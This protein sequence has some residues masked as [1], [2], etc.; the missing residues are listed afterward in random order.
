MRGKTFY[1]MFLLVL[2]IWVA[3]FRTDQPIVAQELSPIL[4]N[5]EVPPF[6]PDDKLDTSD[7]TSLSWME[8]QKAEAQLEKA[9][10]FYT[11]GVP[12]SFSTQGLQAVNADSFGYTWTSESLSWIS[13]EFGTDTNIDDLTDHTGPIDIGFSFNYYENTYTQLYISR[14]GFV[15]FSEEYIY[16]S[17]SEIPSR[18]KPDN[19]IAPHWSPTYNVE[20]YVRYVKGGIYPNRWFAVEWNHVTSSVSTSDTPEN[21]TFEV[22]LYESGDIVFQYDEMSASGSYF[23]QASGIED[24]TGIDGLSLSSY[25]SQI[26]AYSAK[27]IIRPAPAARVRIDSAFQGRFVHPE[28]TE[29]FQFQVRNIGDLGADTFDLL[30]TSS[31]PISLYQAD[32]KTLWS[33]TD[34]D[35]IVDTGALAQGETVTI[36]AKISTPTYVSTGNYNIVTVIARSSRDTNRD[37]SASL[38]LALPAPFVQAYQDSANAV[39]SLDFV[40]PDGVVTGKTEQIYGYDLAV[41]E[42]VDGNFFYAW[43]KGRCLDSQCERYVR[44]I[45]YS[46]FHPQGLL[47]QATTKLIDLSQVPINTYDNALALAVA[48]NGRIG[49]VWYRYH[50]NEDT[51]QSLYNIWFAILN[52][53][54]DLVYGPVNLTNNE[55]WGASGDLNYPRFWDPSIAATTDNRFIIVWRQYHEESEGTVSDI[56]YTIRDTNGTEVKSPAQL[57]YDTAG[58]DGYYKPIVSPLSAS[59]AIVTWVARGF[60]DTDD[61][62]YAVLTSYGSFV[63]STSN[64]S[65]GSEVVDWWNNDVVQLSNGRILATWE[66]W[67]CFPGEWVSRIMYTVLD[68]SYTQ[69]VSPTCLSPNVAAI[70][71][72]MASSLTIDASGHALLSWQDRSDD[73]QNIYYA[74]LDTEGNVLTP[75]V[76]SRTAEGISWGTSSIQISSNGY[77]IAHYSQF[78]APLHVLYLPLSLRGFGEGGSEPPYYFEGPWEVEPNNSYIEAN[79]RLRSAR[80]YYGYPNDLKDYFSI[81]LLEA[82]TITIDLENYPDSLQ[83]QLQLFY[84]AATIENRKQIDAEAPYHI[85]YTGPAGWYY[86]YIN[87]GAIPEDKPRYTLRVTYP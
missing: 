47:S 10:S 37:K 55:Q 24:S 26:G 6:H 34:D 80:D 20:G 5:D 23:C 8:M 74:L 50:Y 43:T 21:Y 52:D 7:V 81:E 84:Q 70:E 40:R 65:A 13:A 67:G 61:I 62:Y 36:I 3:V 1:A 39:P 46:I 32:G 38:Q 72:D 33:D 86:I 15:T 82:G 28:A 4:P 66:G 45:E 51:S 35:G 73:P 85:E 30:T 12:P 63:K 68:S 60:N 42:M 14:F 71:G 87:T 31:W 18:Q 17:Q 29:T 54:A 56:H 22:V 59:R 69:V 53:S 44:E 27:R 49:I 16:N 9:L 2:M 48:P 75:P 58:S 83:G 78:N 77:G 11:P 19:V 57:T 41:A 76:I 64:L 79:G 25:C